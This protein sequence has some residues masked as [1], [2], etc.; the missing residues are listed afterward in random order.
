MIDT[1][2]QPNL[3]AQAD[4]AADEIERALIR[5]INAGLSPAAVLAGAHGSI[6]CIMAAIFGTDATAERCMSSAAKVRSLPAMTPDNALAMA[7][8]MGRA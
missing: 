4:L 6:V 7:R 3:E 1:P 5:L 2:T 8:P